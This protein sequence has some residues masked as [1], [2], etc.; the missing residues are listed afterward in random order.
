MI[1]IERRGATTQIVNPSPSQPCVVNIQVLHITIY[2][3]SNLYEPRYVKLSVKKKYSAILEK[4]QE[5]SKTRS[6]KNV[7]FKHF[8]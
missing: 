6:E 4:N 5:R 1:Q 8:F 3:Q 2:Q 7:R